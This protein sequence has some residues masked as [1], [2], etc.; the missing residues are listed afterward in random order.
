MAR[1]TPPVSRRP[2]R[3]RPAA[4]RLEPDATAPQGVAIHGTTKHALV[5]RALLKDIARGKYPVGGMLPSEPQ[6]TTAF[7]VS[8]QTVR[9]ALRNLRDLGL[10]GGAH[11]VGSFVR[12]RHP[13]TGYA[14]S[15]DSMED[16]LQYATGTRV[17]IASLDEVA[18]DAAQAA[19]LA[20]RKGERWWK[21]RTVRLSPTDATPIAS[22]TI[23]VPYAHGHVLHDLGHAREPIFALIEK[24]MGERTTE[25]AQDIS[26]LPLPAEHAAA[27]E[28]RAGSPALC[29]ERRY[30][31]RNGDLFEVSQSFHPPGAF[32]YSMRLRL[33][34][35][36]S[37]GEPPRRPRAR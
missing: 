10:I 32:H 36:P 2:A 23:M 28:L 11:G 16:L 30:F 7:G 27:L 22:S 29:I 3:P 13:T 15:F 26:A 24:S 34:T 4:R 19:W 31:G 37:A 9:V 14:H 12:A 35:Q 17:V 20:R 5:A 6:L 1:S 18:L 21:V 8:R 33:A 25:V